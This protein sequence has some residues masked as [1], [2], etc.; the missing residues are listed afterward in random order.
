MVQK[1]SPCAKQYCMD[2]HQNT[3]THKM[4]KKEV[5]DD[6]GPKTLRHT[7]TLLFEQEVRAIEVICPSPVTSGFNLAHDLV[8]DYGLTKYQK[9]SCG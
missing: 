8:I 4:N 6:L 3:I 2:P 5:C 7:T 9:Y 1:S